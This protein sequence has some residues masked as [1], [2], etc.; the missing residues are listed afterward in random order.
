MENREAID[1]YLRS[2]LLS[3]EM[4]PRITSFDQVMQ[5]LEKK[6]RRRFFII[7]LS[8][9]AI[10]SGIAA[11]TTINYVDRNVSSPVIA[12]AARGNDKSQPIS[13]AL[14]SREIPASPGRQKTNSIK[15]SA[16]NKASTSM[17]L[18]PHASAK[19]SLSLI[20][21]NAESPLTADQIT[22]NADTAQNMHYE[23]LHPISMFLVSD[24]M[25]A[26]VNDQF[27]TPATE[28]GKAINAKKHFFIGIHFSPQASYLHLM[29]NDN[30]NSSYDT[31]G[32][33]YAKEY[34]QTRKDQNKIHLTYSCGLKFGMQIKNRWELMAG[35]GVQKWRY[36]EVRESFPVPT[37]TAIIPSSSSYNYAL[38]PTAV[39][40]NTFMNVFKYFSLSLETARIWQ[41]RAITVKAGGGLVLQYNYSNSSISAGKPAAYSYDYKGVSEIRKM[42]VTPFLKAG[43]IEDIG[44]RL[45]FQLSPFIYYNPASTFSKD[46]IIKQR[47]MGAGLEMLLLLRL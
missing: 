5:K 21:Q 12:E 31:D 38:A 34:L 46:Y 47:F 32:G 8:G 19:G 39:Q 30:R 37:V 16:G 7:F 10:L 23:R 18:F 35:I 36:E 4:Q 40:S 14:N 22:V 29:E 17:R 33:V 25:P 27:T 20:P 41:L 42:L 11:L 28:T 13:P 6:R 2:S 3:F 24:T 43:I 45:S 15:K 9:I 26:T 1:Q 44:P